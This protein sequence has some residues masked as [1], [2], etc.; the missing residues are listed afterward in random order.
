MKDSD[1]LME[2]ATELEYMAKQN[3]IRLL[4][5]ERYKTEHNTVLDY[6][7]YKTEYN[8]RMELAGKVRERAKRLKGRGE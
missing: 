6:E 2:T 5:Y 4:D 7:R 3:F 8:A 1:I